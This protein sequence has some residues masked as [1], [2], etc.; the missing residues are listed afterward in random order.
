MHKLSGCSKQLNVP[1]GIRK[2]YTHLASVKKH[3]NSFPITDVNAFNTHVHFE[4]RASVFVSSFVEV[5]L[6]MLYVKT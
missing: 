1:L 2:Q 4:H 3:V 6:A 5:S